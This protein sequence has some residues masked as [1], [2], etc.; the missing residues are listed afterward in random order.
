MSAR[1]DFLLNPWRLTVLLN[2][3]NRKMI[4]FASRII[5][6]VFGLDE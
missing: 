2:R 5:F 4:L 6:S 1:S 3:A